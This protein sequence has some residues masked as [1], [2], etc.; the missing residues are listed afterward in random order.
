MPKLMFNLNIWIVCKLILIL[1]SN[2]DSSK[3]DIVTSY[4]SYK[5][6]LRNNWIKKVLSFSSWSSNYF[7]IRC[8]HCPITL[9]NMWWEL[10]SSTNIVK[11]QFFP[12]GHT[13]MWVRCYVGLNLS[14]R[15]FVIFLPLEKIDFTWIEDLHEIQ[16]FSSKCCS[17]FLFICETVAK[18]HLWIN[19]SVIR[20][21]WCWHPWFA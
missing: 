6:N 14:L 13:C 11:A 7:Q 2:W 3:H 8:Y 15:V 4:T 20:I 18:L 21:I 9:P 17:I 19:A 16:E 10:L 12:G 5:L 1:L